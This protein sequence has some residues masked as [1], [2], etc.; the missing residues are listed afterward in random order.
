MRLISLVLVLA[1]LVAGAPCA[2]AELSAASRSEID[3]LLD[4]LGASGCQ[5]N[6]N[7]T[8]YG[9]AKAKSHLA[10]KLDYLLDK[11]L[12]ESPEQFIVLAGTKSSQSGEYYHVKCGNEAAVPSAIWLTE[13]LRELRAKNPQH[14]AGK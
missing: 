1:L 11:K 2:G 5:F 14:G 6:R 4:R 8:W 10:R 9:S 7:G 13:A 12:V 3:A